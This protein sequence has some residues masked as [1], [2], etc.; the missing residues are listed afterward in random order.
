MRVWF[1]HAKNGLAS[2]GSDV[3]GFEIAGEDG[4]FVTATAKIDGATVL[5][6]AAGVKQPRSVRYAWQNFTDANL[7]NKENLPASTFTSE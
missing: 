6:Q 3:K 7:F 1:D 5:V 4:K 2:H